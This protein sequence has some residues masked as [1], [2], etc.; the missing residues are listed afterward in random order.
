MLC[1]DNVIKIP[2]G[3]VCGERVAREVLEAE[4]RW[5]ETNRVERIL[6]QPR[7]NSFFRHLTHQ[8]W[9]EA[10]IELQVSLQ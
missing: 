1:E 7:V 2:Y 9:T 6:P 10:V 5:D 4:K 3:L 8:D